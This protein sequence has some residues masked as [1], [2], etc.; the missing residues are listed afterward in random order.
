M[1]GIFKIASAFIILTAGCVPSLYPLYTDSDLIQ[2]PGLI[3]IWINDD[4]TESWEFEL[5][6]DSVSYNLIQTEKGD[7]KH[8]EAYL[9]QLDNMPFLDTYPDEEIKNDFYKIHL[10]PAHI[11]GR[12]ELMG[13][14]LSLS[15]LDSDWLEEKLD[16]GKIKIAHEEIDDSPVLTASTADLQQLIK[17]YARDPEAFSGQT[18]LHR[19]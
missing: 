13:D 12:I 8:F 14:S 17:E 3:G 11:F 4:N 6:G 1:H 18:I 16:S 7:T 15:L 2:N 10:V 5:A 9:L 19:K